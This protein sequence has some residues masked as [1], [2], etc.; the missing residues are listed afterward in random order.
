M[1][2]ARSGARATVR[3]W[4]RWLGIL[5]LALAAATACAADPPLPFYVVIFHVDH[6]PDGRLTRFDVDSVTDPHVGPEAKVQVDVPDTFVAAAREA[7]EV[8]WRAHPP[9]PEKN[10]SHYTYAYF[11]P[12]EPTRGDIGMDGGGVRFPVMLHLRVDETHEGTIRIPATPYVRKGVALLMA[13]DQFGVRIADGGLTYEKDLERADIVFD[14]WQEPKGESPGEMRLLIHNQSKRRLAFTAE[15]SVPG[16]TGP[17]ETDVLPVDAGKVGKERWPDAI[18]QLRLQLA[19]EAPA[20][21]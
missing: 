18:A 15:M 6:E 8:R 9:S 14:F 16:Q 2:D 21:H 4:T 5:V 11:D 3:G 13:G 20:S 7:L 12:A 10:D 19:P 1:H 17:V